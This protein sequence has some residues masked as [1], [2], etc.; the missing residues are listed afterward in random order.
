[1]NAIFS[2][3]TLTNF[4]TCFQFPSNTSIIQHL[5]TSVVQSTFFDDIF[6]VDYY[7]THS[8][9]HIPKF[10]IG[11]VERTN[12]IIS[13]TN[14]VENMSLTS[15]FEPSS[16]PTIYLSTLFIQISCFNATQTQVIM[17]DNIHLFD[18][19]FDTFTNSSTPNFSPSLPTTKHQYYLPSFISFLYNVYSSNAQFHGI[20]IMKFTQITS[21]NTIFGSNIF[22]LSMNYLKIFYFMFGIL[23]YTPNFGQFFYTNT[24]LYKNTKFYNN[25]NATTATVIAQ[26]SYIEDIT[27]IIL[28]IF[29][30]LYSPRATLNFFDIMNYI[31]IIF[32][33]MFIGLTVFDH[34]KKYFST[35]FYFAFGILSCIPTLEQFFYKC[36]YPSSLDLH[37]PFIKSVKSSHIHNS[38]TLSSTSFCSSHTIET[39]SN[40]MSDYILKVI[41]YT[42]HLIWEPGSSVSLLLFSFP[43]T[44]Y[45]PIDHVCFSQQHHETLFLSMD[46]LHHD[47][48]ADC[49][50][51]HVI[52]FMSTFIFNLHILLYFMNIVF[53]GELCPNPSTVDCLLK[54][55]IVSGYY[56]Q[57]PFSLHFDAHIYHHR[58]STSCLHTINFFTFNP[59]SVPTSNPT[60]F[61]IYSPC[62]SLQRF[63]HYN[64]NN[65]KMI[66]FNIHLSNILNKAIFVYTTIMH[67]HLTVTWNIICSQIT[68]SFFEHNNFLCFLGCERSMIDCYFLITNFTL[69]NHRFTYFNLLYYIR[70]TIYF[71]IMNYMIFFDCSIGLIL[72]HMFHFQKTSSFCIPL[73]IFYL[74]YN[75]LQY[76]TIRM[77]S[78]NFLKSIFASNFH[79]F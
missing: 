7:I 29:Y 44:T 2:S 24:Y 57:S 19:S 9:T 22:D 35:I 16:S 43:L 73:D 14:F 41:T 60:I 1:L 6:M 65:T 53:N 50:F 32:Y 74:D 34:L 36:T 54:R 46:I 64:H 18:C 49:S 66:F 30:G 48:L 71:F 8:F 59:S 23:V 25:L 72:H 13:H 61:L 17:K 77:F 33:N 21:S 78:T 51:L 62:T 26:D 58:R 79:V 12:D 31:N 28:F 70:D 45:L 69:F 38:N 15:S 4:S 5:S 75:I 40:F 63:L 76:D 37:N 55:K 10:I 39:S 11:I 27:M 42:F 68:R 3:S 52:F 56:K 20:D 67:F 47:F